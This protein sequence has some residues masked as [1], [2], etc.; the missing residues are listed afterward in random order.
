MLSKNAKRKRDYIARAN[1]SNG[2]GAAY[3]GGAYADVE[4]SVPKLTGAYTV[5]CGADVGVLGSIK[6]EKP[7]STEQQHALKIRAR[8]QL[9]VAAHAGDAVGVEINIDTSCKPIGHVNGEQKHTPT[10][11]HTGAKGALSSTRLRVTY[12]KRR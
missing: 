11:R 5:R 9:V 2:Y 7:S 3:A 12:K 6:P 10:M 8:Y 4:R 1:Q